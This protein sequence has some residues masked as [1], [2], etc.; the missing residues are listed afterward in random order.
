MSN[1]CACT[2]KAVFRYEEPVER[3][4]VVCALLVL[5]PGTYLTAE[6]S[7][8][9]LALTSEVDG[10]SASVCLATPWPFS[11]DQRLPCPKH[12]LGS[13]GHFASVPGGLRENQQELPR[14]GLRVR[15]AVASYFF[16]PKLW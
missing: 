4:E 16:L 8:I 1:R 6:Y 9:L 3:R 13:V 14:G 5:L 2:A 7:C 11:G 10:I 12:G 15:E